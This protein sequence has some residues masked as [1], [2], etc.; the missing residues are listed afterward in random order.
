LNIKQAYQTNLV[1]ENEE[2][3]PVQE[4]VVQVK[5]K[6]FGITTIRIRI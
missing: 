4:N 1:E 3:I 6:A 5:V 2:S